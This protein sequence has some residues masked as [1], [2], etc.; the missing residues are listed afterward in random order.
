MSINC[1]ASHWSRSFFSMI[2]LMYI[3]LMSGKIWLKIC[4]K[5]C[6]FFYNRP[7]RE[8]YAA[9]I[10]NICKKLIMRKVVFFKVPG[11]EWCT[12]LWRWITTAPSDTHSPPHCKQ[13]ITS[14]YSSISLTAR[15]D[16]RPW[17]YE[18]RGPDSA[19]IEA[20]WRWWNRRTVTAADRSW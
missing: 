2:T 14:H 17:H 19:P 1:Q 9:C 12:L 10:I 5:V 18:S 15:R 8:P 11:K 16:Q 4:G 7:R 6:I 13:L 3:L 20:W